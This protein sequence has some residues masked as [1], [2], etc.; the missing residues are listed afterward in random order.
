MA[1]VQHLEGNTFVG[2]MC[3][4]LLCG[5][6][7]FSLCVYMIKKKK[8]VSVYSFSILKKKKKNTTG[9]DKRVT[10]IISVSGSRRRYQSVLTT[11]RA[12]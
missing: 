7:I 6:G 11:L 8:N 12:F 2:G 4:T 1:L 10:S 5:I 3:S 9:L